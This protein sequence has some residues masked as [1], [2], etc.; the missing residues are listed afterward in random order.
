[1]AI[2]A[3]ALGSLTAMAMVVPSDAQLAGFEQGVRISAGSRY[4][5]GNPIGVEQ[6]PIL[7]WRLESGDYRI[8]HFFGVHAMQIVLVWGWLIQ[9]ARPHARM[10]A[11]MALVLA[12]AVAVL[13]LLWGASMN[14]GPANAPLWLLASSAHAFAVQPVIV[15]LTR[16]TGPQN[17]F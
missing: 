1:M 16:R 5:D 8:A 4:P 9:T 17:A 2:I 13:L 14:Y 6:I 7:G 3:G 15:V 12:N 11:L 10:R